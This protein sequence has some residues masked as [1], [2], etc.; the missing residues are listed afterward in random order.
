MAITCDPN[1]QSGTFGPR[2][3]A[4]RKVLHAVDLYYR[5]SQAGNLCASV[6]MVCLKDLESAGE[7]G[8]TCWET[9]TLTDRAMWRLANYCVATG[10]EQPF[11]ADVREQLLRA[12]QKAP[13]ICTLV[14][15][16]Y[17]GKVKTRID[18]V[19]RWSGQDNEDGRWD[20]YVQGAIAAFGEAMRRMD[21][22]S[23]GG[24]AGGGSSTRGWGSGSGSAQGAEPSHPSSQEGSPADYR[25][26]DIPF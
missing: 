18:K 10:Y 6:M 16:E 21:A 25:D 19:E 5:R 3:S 23:S 20:E 14:E 8:A 2:I 15:D 12:L 22:R 4:G 24:S 13:T 17:D 1:K 26:E 11:E 7:E 9:Y